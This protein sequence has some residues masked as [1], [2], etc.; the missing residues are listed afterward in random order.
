MRISASVTTLESYLTGAGRRLGAIL[1]AFAGDLCTI[2]QTNFVEFPFQRLSG[3]SLCG[4]NGAFFGSAKRL[5]RYHFAPLCRLKGPRNGARSDFPDSLSTLDFSHWA[6]Q[7]TALLWVP[8]MPLR[9]FA[10]RCRRP[11]R[12]NSPKPSQALKSPLLRRTSRRMGHSA[13]RTA[14]EPGNWARCLGVAPFGALLCELCGR[15]GKS[16]GD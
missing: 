7:Q 5:I 13:K 9:L 2:V 11:T 8:R 1:A 12:K 4:S 16:G 3:K 10:G 14:T 15:H 6:V